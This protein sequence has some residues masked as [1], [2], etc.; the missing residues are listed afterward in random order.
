MPY[1]SAFP[2]D[3][4]TA[5]LP[6]RLISK[7]TPT[8]RMAVKSP[9]TLTEVILPKSGKER[10]DMGWVIQGKELHSGTDRKRRHMATESKG[11]VQSLFNCLNQSPQSLSSVVI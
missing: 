10:Q 6:E 5:N 9:E 8:K 4:L 11:T 3:Y 2:P 1:G 7:H